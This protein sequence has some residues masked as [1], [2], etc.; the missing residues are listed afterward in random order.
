M[1]IVGWLAAILGVIGLVICLV[2]AIGVWLVRPDIVTR[3]DH[4]ASIAIEGL[5][6]AAAL[7]VDASDLTVEVGER[8]D[9]VASTAQQVSEN[10]IL[11]AAVDRLLGGAITNLVSGPWNQVQDRLGGMRER[12]VT[13]SSVVQGLDSA[14]PFIE[15]PGVATAFVD[16]VDA[17]WTTLDERVQ[18]METIA[19]EGVGTAER[20]GRIAQAATEASERL[21]AVNVALGEVHGKIEAAQADIAAAAD[22]AESTLTWVALVICIISVWVGLLHLLLIAQ[23]RRWIRAEA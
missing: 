18:E 8:L 14:I 6:Q 22:R 23:G 3:V 20:A 9:T 21:A 1:R 10:P 5:D 19:S 17:R 2:I 16:D 12:V 15:L 11:D 4:I 7:S 13:L